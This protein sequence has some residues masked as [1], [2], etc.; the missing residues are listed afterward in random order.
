MTLESIHCSRSAH[1]QNVLARRSQYHGC[2]SP[3]S[4]K[5]EQD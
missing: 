4:E 1:D 5:I 3:E 2:L